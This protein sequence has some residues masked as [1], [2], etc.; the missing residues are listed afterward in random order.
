MAVLPVSAPLL[1]VLVLNV[2]V[3]LASGSVAMS[4][5]ATL[6]SS[7]TATVC[8]M[9]VGALG[10]TTAVPSGQR[11]V[12]QPMSRSAHT[13]TSTRLVKSARILGSMSRLG[14]A[15]VVQCEID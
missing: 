6:A 9:A 3:E 14:V 13:V 10:D 2:S 4:V 11:V 5:M 1:G 7:T 12:C 15:N 8:D